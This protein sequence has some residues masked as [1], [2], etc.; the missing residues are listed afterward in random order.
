MYYIAKMSD[1]GKWEYLDN[2]PTYSDAEDCYDLY[3]EM[4]PHALVEIIASD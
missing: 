2:L 4:Y 3:C 1:E